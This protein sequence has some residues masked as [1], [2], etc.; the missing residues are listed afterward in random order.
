[1]KLTQILLPSLL[2]CFILFTSCKKEEDD[3]NNNNSNAAFKANIDG[4][5]FS[6]NSA[7]AKFVSS[8]KM[9][10]IIGQNPNQNGTLHFQLMSFDGTVSTAA[11]WET[12]EYNFDPVNITNW[13]YSASA[14]YTVLENSNYVNWVTK[15]EHVQAGK[16]IIESNT[17]TQIT[18][19]FSVDLV[20]QNSDG[21]FDT[22][23]IKKV[24]DG[25]FNVKISI[26]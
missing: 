5:T 26:Y 11:D 10:Q 17:G 12:K 19:K 15:W 7:S 6:T 24:T 1:M 2:G 21:S 22:N 14:T 25:E 3:T 18:G 13:I 4:T 20:K 16:I 9:L 23:N 8:T